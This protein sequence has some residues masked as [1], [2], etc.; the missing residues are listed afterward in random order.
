MAGDDRYDAFLSFC[1]ADEPWAREWLLPRLEAAGLRICTEEHFEGGAVRLDEYERLVD[2]SRHVLLVISPAWLVGPWTNFTGL[3]GQHDD[4]TNRRRKILPL[5]VEP[6]ALPRRLDGLVS[7]DFTGRRDREREVQKLLATLCTVDAPAADLSLPAPTHWTV[8]FLRNEHFVGRD[9]DLER[10]HAALS[11]ETL[12]GIRPTGLTGQGGIGKTQLAVEY[13]FRHATDYPDGVFW[14]NAAEDWRQ[15]FAAL[16]RRVDP[17]CEDRP[18]EQQLRAAARYLTAHP[19]ALLVLDNVE[20]P[21]ALLRP[22]IP[23]LIPS[24][25]PV[26]TIFTTRRRDLGQFQPVEVTVLPAAA[27]DLLLSHHSRQPVRQPDHPEHRTAHEICAIL[28]YLPL[29]VEIAAAHLGRNPA[30]PLIRYRD[31]LLK[32]GALAV[33]DDPRGQVRPDDL[34]TRH[35]AA[36]EATLREQYDL[37]QNDDARLLLRVAGQLAEAAQ[38]PVARLGL[39]AGVSDEDDDFF[40][41]PLRLAADEL[42]DTSFVESLTAGQMRLHPLVREFAARC[43]PMEQVLAFRRELAVCLFDA[44]SHVLTLETHCLHRGI[45]AVEGDGL[46]ALDLLTTH[47]AATG[48]PDSLLNEVITRLCALLRLLERFSHEIRDWDAHTYPAFFAQQIRNRAVPLALNVLHDDALTRL[49]ALAQRYLDLAWGTS[50]AAP[51]LIR[52]LL[53]HEAIIWSVAVTADGKRVVSASSDR[54]LR[55]WDLD[56]GQSIATLLGHEA[57]EPLRVMLMAV[58]ADGKRAL[59]ALNN[60]ALRIW[61]LDTGQSIATLVGHEASM[62]GVAVTPDGKRAVSASADRTLRVWDLD[63]GECLAVAALDEAVSAVAVA[64]DGETIVAGDVVGNVYFCAMW[65]R[66]PPSN[67]LSGVDFLKRVSEAERHRVSPPPALGAP[68]A[69]GQGCRSPS[70]SLA[71]TTATRT[72]AFAAFTRSSRLRSPAG[73]PNMKNLPPKGGVLPCRRASP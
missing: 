18:L 9:P 45:S 10:L 5:I 70:S 61:D 59:S 71:S 14:V 32:R 4:P 12:V 50:R 65:S 26:R 69:S 20:D 41:S 27:L 47:S 52:T 31:A 8:P 42:F 17:T 7:F 15:G 2:S 37:L 54:T 3:I 1:T 49:K 56:T 19:Q 38:I 60:G 11:G 29:A 23:E 22:L 44:Y 24:A 13:C 48:Q 25:L 73:G 28:G 21:A 33:V 43:T 53:G 57:R 36:V 46:T 6:T 58:T 62:N 34:G 35:A 39:L 63:S 55:V 72:L 30:Q 64:L 68:L 51:A 16:G 67:S 66:R 40:G